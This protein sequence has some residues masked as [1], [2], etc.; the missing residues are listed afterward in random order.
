MAKEVKE[1]V[2]ETKKETVDNP[3]TVEDAPK[4]F[5]QSEVNDLIEKR[6]AKLEKLNKFDIISLREVR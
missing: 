2:L 4:T 3:E 5:T 1:D 6:L